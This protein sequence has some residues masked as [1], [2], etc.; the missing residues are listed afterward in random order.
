MVS[1]GRPS[2]REIDLGF[3]RTISKGTLCGYLSRAMVVSG[4]ITCGGED[5]LRMV[6]STGARYIARAG[7]TWVPDKAYMLSLPRQKETIAAIHERDHDMILEACIFENVGRAVNDIAIPEHVFAA[8]GLPAEDRCYSY[9]RMVFRFGPNRDRFGPGMSVPDMRR[10]EAR[11]FFYHLACEHIDAGYEGLHL[12]Q[13]HLMG[14]RDRRWTRWTDLLRKVRSYAR[15]HARRG[16]VLVNA[17]TFGI[18][19]AD[20]RLLFDFHSF[21]VR[22][23]APEG[24]VPHPPTESEPQEIVPGVGLGKDRRDL[25]YRDSIFT[26]SLGGT[27]PSGWECDSLPYF[28]ELDN[29]N[30]FDPRLLDRPSFG[31]EISWWGFDE[32]SWFANQPGAYRAWWLENLHEWI[33]EIDPVGHLEM[34]GRRTAALRR[35]DGSI[36]QGM[37]S[38]SINGGF[39]DEDAIRRLW[40]RTPPGRCS[41]SGEA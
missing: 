38:A 40:S 32:I 34:P 39:G 17:H 26:H 16:M 30:G 24:S 29:W 5:D 3:D 6:R 12:G 35:P 1:E 9:G 23:R 13:V 21:P 7:G 33:Q 36:H 22:G 2:D 4:L 27:A 15:D 20:G 18:T 41:R 37:Y 14:A 25:T 19:G 10:M 8:F 31:E 11:M 28:V